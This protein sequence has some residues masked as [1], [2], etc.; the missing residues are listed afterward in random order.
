VDLPGSTTLLSL[1]ALS[2]P[3]VLL[4]YPFLSCGVSLLLLFILLYLFLIALIAFM[5]LSPILL[6]VLDE[7]GYVRLML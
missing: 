3:L 7:N 2:T 4:V 5:V 6:R 1:T